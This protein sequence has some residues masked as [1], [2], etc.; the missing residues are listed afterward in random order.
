MIDTRFTIKISKEISDCEQIIKDL[1]IIS[2]D[3][4]HKIIAELKTSSK[5]NY[6]IDF[7]PIDK[8][9]ID[10]LIHDFVEIINSILKSEIG[11][12]LKIHKKISIDK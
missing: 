7:I 3:F 2:F 4:K 11:T 10:N 6:Y 12:T 8:I 5:N 1:Q 9:D